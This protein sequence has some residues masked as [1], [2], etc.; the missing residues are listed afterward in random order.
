MSEILHSSGKLITSEIDYQEGGIVSKIIS[1]TPN[2][3]IT[4]FSFW[5][6]Q[7]ISKHTSPF[8]AIIICFEG[9]VSV[10]IDTTDYVL[11]PIEYIKL[12]A[13]VPHSLKALENSKIMLMMI[14][15]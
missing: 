12:P 15:S 9:K 7:E 8:E 5:K 2:G 1:K 14:K 11:L 3:N 6:E 4:L 13:N 10:T